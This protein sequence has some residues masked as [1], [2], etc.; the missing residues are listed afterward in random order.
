MIEDI[1]T[2]AWVA[3]LAALELHVPL[4]SADD[5]ATPREMIFDLDPGAPAGTADCIEIARRLAELLEQMKLKS[6][7]KFSGKKGVHLLVPLNTRG[8]TFDDTK[9][10]ARAVAQT[11]ARDDPK[12]ITAVMRKEDR[13]G[14]VFIDW[15]QNDDSK[16]NVCAYS[17]RAADRP[18]I[19]WPIDLQS[20]PKSIPSA[21][22]VRLPARDP[23]APL[24]ALRQT[25]PRGL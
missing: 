6:F 2:L 21:D 3:N 7:A 18:Q 11:L 12:R 9:T 10:F 24:L 1:S 8:V 13:T 20:P 16:T 5:P 15:G 14:K 25:L 17:L 22:S 4:A 19:S 23:L